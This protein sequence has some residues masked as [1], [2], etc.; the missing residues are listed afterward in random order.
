MEN[1]DTERD[2]VE[3]KE[4]GSERGREIYIEGEREREREV[5]DRNL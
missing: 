4:G 3:I 5:K 1:I 2:K